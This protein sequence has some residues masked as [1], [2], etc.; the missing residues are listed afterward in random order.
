MTRTG[1]AGSLDDEAALAAADPQDMLGRVEGEAAQWL[2]AAAAA[3]SFEAPPLWRGFREV[4]VA[5]MGGSAIASDLLAAWLERRWPVRLHT[6]RDYEL[7]AWAG[8]DT[9]L[10][11]SS[12]SGN[13]EETL[14]AWEQAGRLGLERAA[15]TTG[16]ELA[17]LA[18]REGTPL[19][20]LEA[21]YPPRAALPMSFLTLAGLLAGVG[22]AESGP[23]GARSREELDAIPRILEETT[24]RCGRTVPLD[25]NPAKEL[26]LWLGDGLPVL[27][28]PRDP[29]EAV[30]RRWRGQ[31]NEN[32]KRLAWGGVLPELDHNEI[33]GWPARP[34][35]GANTRVLFLED[36]DQH[37]RV[38]RRIEVTAELVAA[39]GA[40][41]RRLSGQAA[42][43]LGRLWSLVALGDFVSVYLALATGID[44]TPV[45]PIEQLKSRLRE[46]IP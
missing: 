6:L 1:P 7:P 15:V 18:R 5:G 31:F 32:A 30:A 13:T 27:Y 21:D 11:A 16:G 3:A 43:G 24:G 38:S 25:R 4:I 41:L 2:R 10:V 14:N 37:P 40:P 20:E 26:A 42:G 35:L 17:H 39:A 44:P 46:D 36:P 29:L 34:W 9:L 19:V 22:P 8:P 33:V 45:V 28:A 12:Y 23:G